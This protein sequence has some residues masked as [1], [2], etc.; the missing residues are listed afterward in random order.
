LLQYTT[1]ITVPSSG[2]DETAEC[3][4]TS[5]E[6]SAGGS[7]VSLRDELAGEAA[8]VK[9]APQEQRLLSFPLCGVLLAASIGKAQEE[10]AESGW[11]E[12]S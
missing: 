12:E 8:L 10:D 7:C 9:A 1:T 6:R 3:E 4:P 11:G 2:R 5:K